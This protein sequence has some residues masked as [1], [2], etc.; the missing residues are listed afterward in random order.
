[1]H[2]AVLLARLLQQPPSAIRRSAAA[3][4]PCYHPESHGAPAATASDLP[5]E[6]T[7]TATSDAL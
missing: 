7:T 3:A 1:M 6:T 5:L 2:H 4:L